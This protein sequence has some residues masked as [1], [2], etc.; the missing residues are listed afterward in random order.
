M[1]GDLGLHNLLLTDMGD[2]VLCDFAGYG[3]DG[4]PP[5]IAYGMRYTD[6]CRRQEDLMQQ[7]DVFAMGTLMYELARGELLFE[8]LEDIY[9]RLEKKLFPDTSGL[10]APL[11]HVIEKCQTDPDYTAQDALR[12]LGKLPSLVSDV[13]RFPFLLFS[14]PISCRTATRANLNTG[15]GPFQ[16]GHL[17]ALIPALAVVAVAA[18][19]IWSKIAP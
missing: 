15:G 13:L 4:R 2:L 7:H 6:L 1:H 17:A 9:E 10:P 3:I 11:K 12:D 19:R 5:Y 16:L 14:F 8:G 18:W